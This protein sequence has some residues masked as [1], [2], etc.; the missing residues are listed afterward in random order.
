MTAI[1]LPPWLHAPLRRAGDALASGR[2]AHGLL[3]CGPPRIGK[4]AFAYALAKTLLCR[5][6]VDGMACGHCRDCT[7]FAASGPID[8]SLTRPDGSL[9]LPLG[10]PGHPD[11]RMLGYE[12]NDKTGKMYSVLTVD[13][14]RA[15]GEWLALTSQ[16]GGAQVAVIDPASAMNENAANALLKTLEEPL[17]GRYLMLCCESPMQLPATIRSRCQR[18]VLQLPSVDVA[19]AWLREQGHAQAPARTALMAARGNPGLAAHWLANGLLALRESVHADLA[20]IAQ[21]KRGPL[22][23]AAAWLGDERTGERLCFAAEHALERASAQPAGSSVDDSSSGRVT[24]VA[25][26]AAWFDDANH[27]RDL[28]RTPIRADLALA[29]LLRRWR[30]AASVA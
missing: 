22:E 3:V 23:M 29:D 1:D 10:R 7:L 28:L 14:I 2:L 13:Q 17:P 19:L 6:R 9:S 30:Q 27:T 4:Q 26:L 24:D 12:R 16:R 11:A 21:G 20:A 25:K 15:L 18:I 5:A 8:A